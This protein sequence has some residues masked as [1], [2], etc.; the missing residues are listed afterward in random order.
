MVMV[1]SLFLP[2]AREEDETRRIGSSGEEGGELRATANIGGCG[3]ERGVS[4][5]RQ[6]CGG[7]ET[8]VGM[9]WNAGRGNRERE[10]EVTDELLEVGMKDASSTA[11]SSTASA[12]ASIQQRKWSNTPKKDRKYF[13][14]FGLLNWSGFISSPFH[15]AF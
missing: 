14:L 15:P 4:A 5:W 8:Y 12:S 9:E 11:S 13:F 6:G 3:A 2:L 1:M 7:M 10:R